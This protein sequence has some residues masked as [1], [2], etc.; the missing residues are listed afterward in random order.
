MANRVGPRGLMFLAAE[1]VFKHLIFIRNDWFINFTNI[2]ARRK[3]RQI[4]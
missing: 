1:K 2:S 3:A 4:C